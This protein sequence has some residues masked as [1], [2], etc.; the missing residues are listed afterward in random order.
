MR[1]S[2]CLALCCCGTHCPKAQW[3]K[4]QPPYCFSRSW[5]LAGAHLGGL[6]LAS[7]GIS[8]AVREQHGLEGMAGRLRLPSLS[9]G[10]NKAPLW[11]LDLRTSIP[12]ASPCVHLSSLWLHHSLVKIATRGFPGG[13]AVESLPA[14]AGDTGS[15]P[16][17][18]RS[19]MPRSN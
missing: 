12:G 10:L 2:S 13:A 19:H 11:Q 5:G 4:Q 18:G 8:H 1:A 3:L 7:T 9:T 6:L 17:L 15:S 14:S 16:G